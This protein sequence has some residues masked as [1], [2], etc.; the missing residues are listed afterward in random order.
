MRDPLSWSLNVGRISGIPVRL[1]MFFLLFAGFQLVYAALQP[2][3]LSPAASF[4]QAAAFLTV[5]FG[6]VLLHE[7][8]HCTAATRLGGQARE[9]LLWP[10]GGLATVDYPPAP[11]HE[12]LVTAAG[13]S[14]NFVLGTFS[15]ALLLVTGYRPP[16]RPLAAV[17]SFEGE[18]LFE[19][20]PFWVGTFFAVNLMLVLFNLLPAFPMDGGRLLRSVL[21]TRLGYRDATLWAVQ[22]AKLTAIGM[23]LVAVYLGLQ[24]H[25]VAHTVLLLVGI[26]VY[27][28]AELE[29]HRVAS[30]GWLA[31]DA[32]WDASAEAE[33]EELE[34]DRPL[35]KARPKS[36]WRRWL[37][38]WRRAR[39][40]RARRIERE[41]E[42]LMDE[43]LDQVRKYGYD[44]LTPAQQRFLKR[45]SKRYRSKLESRQDW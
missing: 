23:V 18:L 24:D 13:P 43:L 45:V 29:R 38:R 2:G 3:F 44:S 7:L 39:E 12:F 6:L 20:W 31:A 9:I 27:H 14:V 37:E 10:L 41:E 17:K 22:V 4:L 32:P 42:R 33:S 30:E 19:G 1:H 11:R 15:A 5:L 26:F 21:W 34:L 40:E 8:G 25:R 28:S 35:P 36:W 16:W